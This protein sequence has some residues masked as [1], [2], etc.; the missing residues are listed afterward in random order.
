MQSRYDVLVVGAGHA[1]ANV[2]ARL[3][4][5][6]FEGS[7]GI[8]GD[9]PEIPYERPP[10]SKEYFTGDKPF[11]K[12]LLR[13]ASFWAENDVDVVTG[14]SVAG[15]DAD[16][17]EVCTVGGDVVEYR[18]LVWAAGGRPRALQVPGSQFGGIEALRTKADAD[19]LRAA[20][21]RA[22]DVI[23]V[24]GGYIGL[25]AAAA[26][27]KMGKRVVVLEKLSRVLARV[28]GDE[29]A[30]FYLDEHRRRGVDIRL[31]A[32]VESFGGTAESVNAAVLP[33][34]VSLDADLV[35]VGIGIVPET[36]PLR[37]AGARCGNGVRV[38][39]FC[40]TSL[41]GIYAIGD[42]AE[43]VNHYAGGAAIRLESVQNA[44][45]MAATAALH[46]IG[47]APRPY[48]SVPWFW[49]I[50]YDLRLQTVGI[51]LGHD[52]TVVRGDP[53]NRSFSVVYLREGRVIALD[54]VNAPR[55][56]V[57]GKALIVSGVQVPADAL[58]DAT[59]ALKD[60]L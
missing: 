7:V 23:I 26:L 22:R 59:V 17:R 6:G 40:R 4:R 3:R 47:D 57:Q 35:I 60:L 27:N 9:E 25:E 8:L 14:V 54:C 16:R 20:A 12:M 41:D 28:A 58:G 37:E 56:Y 21:E 15:V 32:E 50:Q 42:C 51:S 55:D 48:D 44:S 31:G 29:L 2:A 46:I 34:G 1:G 11:E 52:E 30:A 43:H 10:L 39:E 53:G 24:G 36:G 5:G 38:D 45:D 19:R 49:S 13:P 33:G 18:K